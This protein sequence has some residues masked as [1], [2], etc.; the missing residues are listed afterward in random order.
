M[1]NTAFVFAGLSLDDL[2]PLADS[3]VSLMSME[4]KAN[5]RIIGAS[6]TR[7]GGNRNSTIVSE[8]G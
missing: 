7:K 4:R 8:S 6:L 1:P 3:S 2:K 5:I